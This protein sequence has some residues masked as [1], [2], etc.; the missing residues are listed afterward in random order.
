M[1][2]WKIIEGYNYKY[3]VSN[4]GNIRRTK[5]KK[6]LKKQLRGGYF[7]VSLCIHGKFNFKSVN[8]LVAIAFISNPENKPQVNHINGKKDDDRVENLEW[9]TRSENIRHAIRIGLKPSLPMPEKT[10]KAIRERNIIKV[11][12]IDS[13]I[14]YESIKSASES[15]GINR[16][17][18]SQ[19]LSGSRT[20]KT[21]LKYY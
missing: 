8:R 10:R 3:E 21:S 13:G 16:H 17:T 4:T 9:C 5:D 1:E 12:D 18:L 14:V 7:R 2:K 19:Y 15:I 20:N 11:I 6:I